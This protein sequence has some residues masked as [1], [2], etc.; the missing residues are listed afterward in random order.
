MK[1]IILAVFLCLGGCAW[2]DQSPNQQTPTGY[3][4]GAA[5]QCNGFNC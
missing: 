2:A 3:P 5:P 4:V 1:I